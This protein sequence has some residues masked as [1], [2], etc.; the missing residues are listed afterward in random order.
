MEPIIKYLCKLEHITINIVEKLN[1]YEDLKNNWTFKT[2][3]H[4][5]NDT[6][7]FSKEL[8]YIISNEG[9]NVNKISESAL[10]CIK[11]K[12]SKGAEFTVAALNYLLF[13][14][15]LDKEHDD[16]EL[17]RSFMDNLEPHEL[18]TIVSEFI[19]FLNKEYLA[20]YKSLN[21]TPVTPE[22]WQTL[23]LQVSYISYF[24]DPLNI[25]SLMVYI[26]PELIVKIFNESKN[27]IKAR[28]I[29][30][31]NEIALTKE[32]M[33]EIINAKSENRIFICSLII[34]RS[35][36]PI[37]YDS[38][39]SG[40]WD[41]LIRDY[42]SN[43]IGILHSLYGDYPITDPKRLSYLRQ[44]TIDTLIEATKNDSISN[45]FTKMVWPK[46]FIPFS[47]LIED[48]ELNNQ[49]DTFVFIN[50][51]QAFINYILELQNNKVKIVLDDRFIYENEFLN[52][53]NVNAQYC[54]AYTLYSFLNCP[55]NLWQILLDE[56]SKL[57]YYI[58]LLYYGSFSSHHAAKM[59]TENVLLI[60]LSINNFK[61]DIDATVQKRFKQLTTILEKTV[62][63]PYIKLSEQ[64]DIIWDEDSYITK[65]A[66]EGKI[67]LIN[68]YLG[69]LKNKENLKTLL[70]EILNFW[71]TNSTTIWP[72]MRN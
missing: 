59:I 35:Y 23:I 2:E 3:Q 27:V 71:N 40:I 53:Y 25:L 15:R 7:A 30:Y 5:R 44:L 18:N 26:R 63:S 65:A 4:N 66:N 34:G 20:Q 24:H 16:V 64:S 69:D 1:G 49:Q 33:I 56:L 28:L 21:Q 10:H 72:W 13:I 60:I 54:V 42:G 37:K 19:S 36:Y 12:R 9:I 39:D 8:G 43:F 47:G 57:L 48:L 22:D 52:V 14:D 41:I 46:N 61:I 67:Y 58:K 11:T 6:Y 31:K 17:L 70:E 32:N 51:T 68:Q 29:S 50:Y 45:M 38:I 55:E 62:L